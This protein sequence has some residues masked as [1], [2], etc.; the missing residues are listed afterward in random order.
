MEEKELADLIDLYLFGRIGSQDLAR[1]KYL[2]KTDPDIDLQVRE[3]QEAFKL[4]KYL[5]YKQLRQKLRQIDAADGR[6]ANVFMKYRWMLATVFI[7]TS[8][9]CLWLWADNHFKPESMAKRYFN[10][11]PEYFMLYQE[12]NGEDVNK[13][14]LATTAFNQKKFH[15]AIDLFLSFE[16]NEQEEISAAAKWNTLLAHFALNGPGTEWKKEMIQ[17]QSTTIEPYRSESIR[18]LRT[19]NS[20]WY[21]FCISRISGN[22]SALKPRLM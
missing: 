7:V 6:N 15:L 8:F 4:L 18:M 14:V 17:F 22:L 1:L 9:F 12:L 5:R 21:R 20:P 11:T 2:R 16:K 19:I 10:A 3:S 13:W